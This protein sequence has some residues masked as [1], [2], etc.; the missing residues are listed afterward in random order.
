MTE[1]DIILERCKKSAAAMR[2]DAL[3]MAL[4]AGDAHLGG[5]LSL[6]EI[7]AV[8]YMGV[9]RIRTDNP[10]WDDRDRLIFSKGHGTL[11]LYTALQQAGF[12]PHEDLAA[13]KK[14]D[15]FLYGHPSMNRAK[16]IEFSSGS[17]GQG[18][19]LAVGSA[20]ALRRRG[21]STARFF[22]IL[23]DGE[24]NEGSVWEAAASAA[25]YGLSNLIAVID[26]NG[27]QYDGDTEQ[28]MSFADMAEKW[29]SFGWDAADV[30]GHDVG[31]LYDSLHKR[32]DKPLAV[33][34]HTIKGKGVS[35]M[36]GN[37][38]W[39]HA[40]FTQKHYEQALAELEGEA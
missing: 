21:N 28:V 26:K 19:S 32:G 20:L 35:F 15:T 24:C 10:D 8:L 17:L 18:V 25:H 14:I 29:R 40:R 22:V 11:A 3:E 34:A 5:G 38:L 30:D 4:S 1:R 31:A 6:I 37:H 27:L 16:G 12:F 9:M 2:R 36:E 33:I 7:M 23:G 13:F 39:H